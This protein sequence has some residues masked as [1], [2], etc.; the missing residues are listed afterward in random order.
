MQHI[1]V[2]RSILNCYISNLN[3]NLSEYKFFK[4]HQLNLELYLRFN[5]SPGKKFLA[6][7]STRMDLDCFI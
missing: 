4:K 3:N 1:H 7:P 6:H 5:A 2:L